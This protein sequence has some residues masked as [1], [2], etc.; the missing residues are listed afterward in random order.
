MSRTLVFELPI[1][2]PTLVGDWGVSSRKDVKM[3]VEKVGY[4]DLALP[5]R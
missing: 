1:R 3:T 5:D 4:I 2:K